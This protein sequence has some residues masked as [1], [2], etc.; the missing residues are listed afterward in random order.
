MAPA[1]E[2]GCPVSEQVDTV[3]E[4]AALHDAAR[5][6]L[7]EWDGNPA[8]YAHSAKW[9]AVGDLYDLAKAAGETEICKRC[10]DFEDAILRRMP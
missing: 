8:M 1:P 4:G 5:N 2:T 3:L 6:I 10:W 7:A 9:R